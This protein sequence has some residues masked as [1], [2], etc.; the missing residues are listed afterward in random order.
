M[1]AAGEV[2]EEEIHFSKRPERLEVTSLLSLSSRV[3]C[4]QQQQQQRRRSDCGEGGG[5]AEGPPPPA[6]RAAKY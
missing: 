4:D 6:A 5:P 1:K 2:V 3:S